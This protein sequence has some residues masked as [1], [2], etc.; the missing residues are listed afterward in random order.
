MRTFFA[1]RARARRIHFI[2]TEVKIVHKNTHNNIEHRMYGQ[3]VFFRLD[4]AYDI[5]YI[6]ESVSVYNIHPNKLNE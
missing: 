4:T 1:N 6:L 5:R 2:R 3:V